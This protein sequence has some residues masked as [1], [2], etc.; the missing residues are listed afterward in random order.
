M[1]PPPIQLAPDALPEL[2]ERFEQAS[3]TEVLRWAWQEFGLRAAIGTSFQGAGLV[4]IHHAVTAGLPLPV[5]TID[6]GLLFSETNELKSRLENFFGIQIEPLVPELSLSQQEAELGERL[7]ERKPDLC[8]TLRKVV[9]LQKKLAKLEAWITGLR[10][11]QSNARSGTQVLEL[12]EFDRIR[13]KQILKINPLAAWSRDDVW[14]YIRKHGIP[15]N[16]LHDR[17][18]RSIGCKPCTRAVVSGQD[19]RAGRW[20]GF[21]KTECGIHT[22]MGENI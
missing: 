19:E 16:P 12:Y 17:G 18:F 11:D 9:P 13:E 15:Y 20:I 1:Q 3:P 6:T 8:C 4:I 14:R 2:S 10:R 7:W 5:F 21:E 22:F